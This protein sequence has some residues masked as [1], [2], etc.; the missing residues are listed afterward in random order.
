MKQIQNWI[1]GSYLILT[2]VHNLGNSD[3]I[4]L[5]VAARPPSP[6]GSRMSAIIVDVVAARFAQAEH[7]LFIH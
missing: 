2:T 4:R 1:T 5:G 7:Q 6:L 3:L